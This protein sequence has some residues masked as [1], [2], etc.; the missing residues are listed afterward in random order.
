MK[1]IFT[2][3]ILISVSFF[4]NAQTCPDGANGVRWLGSGDGLF[5]MD[6][7]TANGAQ[8]LF[9]N[10]VSISV[11]DGVSTVGTYAAPNPALNFTAEV[12]ASWRVVNG[13][14]MSQRLRPDDGSLYANGAGNNSTMTGQVTFNLTVGGPLVCDYIGSVLP[15]SLTKFTATSLEKKVLLE[16]ETE[17][18]INNEYMAV[19]RSVD[20]RN[21]IEIGKV[22]GA[23]NSTFLNKYT[24]EDV[25][26]ENGVNY[27]RL[28]QVD[29]DGSAYYSEIV[30]ATV[31]PE[32]E[33][34]AL[35]VYPTLLKSGDMLTIDM[36][37]L[38]EGDIK[39][40]IFNMNG[41][42]VRQIQSLGA[43]E[44]T[45]SL[46]DIEEGSYL[47]KIE[48]SGSNQTGRFIKI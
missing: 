46:D 4:L 47:I 39:I 42:F 33:S 25:S 41:Q 9:D 3:S 17:L 14:G 8:V 32:E 21:Y 10:L 45:I 12:A 5:V 13:P 36:P 31:R 15:I 26:P 16:W 23:G 24:L 1:N 22:E 11:A 29:F 19:E 27:Y 7:A 2:L 28:R 37:D 44:L 48:N 43:E 30:Q 38:S 20:G 6:W 40:E 34:G 35:N 18:E